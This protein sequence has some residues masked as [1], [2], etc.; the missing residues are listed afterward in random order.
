[1]SSDTVIVV[2]EDRAGGDTFAK[3]DMAYLTSIA[4]KE[5]QRRSRICYWP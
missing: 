4:R 2:V 5:R 1:V 3:I